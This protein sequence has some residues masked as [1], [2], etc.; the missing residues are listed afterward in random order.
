MFS[1]GKHHI[2]RNH[3]FY[4]LVWVLFDSPPFRMGCCMDG[5]S[6]RYVPRPLYALLLHQQFSFAAPDPCGS[7]SESYV[8]Q[9]VL[10][11]APVE[12]AGADP[13]TA[14]AP[15]RK[16]RARGTWTRR[17]GICV[18]VSA[19]SLKNRHQKQQTTEVAN[20]DTEYR[21]AG[22]RHQVNYEYKD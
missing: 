14:I 5:P 22:Q 19:K 8:F 3:F 18:L 4:M 17:K 7:A 12:L 9:G 20:E 11:P 1:N 15:R 10:K 2:H 13:R 21:R 16:G 6:L